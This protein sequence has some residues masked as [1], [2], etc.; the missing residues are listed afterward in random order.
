MTVT[1]FQQ[2]RG[3]SAQWAADDIVL[4]DGEFGVDKDTGVIKLGDGFTVWSQLPPIMGSQ[5]LPLLGKAKDSYRFDGLQTTDFLR[6][7]RAADFLPI[8]G[9]AADADK[10][11]GIDSTGFLKTS[12]AASFL[13]AT[14]KAVD[15]DLLDGYDVTAFALAAD[16]VSLISQ[17]SVYRITTT[18]WGTMTSF[19][20][21]AGGA[22]PGDTVLRS[23]VG[24]GGSL[25]VYVAVGKGASGWVHKGHLNCTSTTRPGSPLL[26]DGLHIY[27]TDTKAYGY[28]D[29]TAGKWRMFDT[30]WQTYTPALPNGMSAGTGGGAL[31]SGAYM[32]RGTVCELRQ[33]FV[34]GTTG[35]SAGTG[36]YLLGLPTGLPIA[37][38][39]GAAYEVQLFAKIWCS[40]GNVVGWAS[41]SQAATSLGIL[42]PSSATNNTFA[43]YGGT[44]PGSWSAG[45]NIFV[46]G[47]YPIG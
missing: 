46:S 6:S 30:V 33:A 13:P 18:N 35:I 23:D 31:V 42:G 7:S 26:Y 28:Y 24:T 11:D 45:N 22:L 20:T 38:P 17:T 43:A 10:L 32:R 9:K 34:F 41:G 3:T 36:G 8:N 15:S 40:I 4:R 19:P 27:E 12:D 29:G 21:K 25:W 39:G 37:T 2:K 14:G 44:T 1:R 47:A 5:Y 16:V